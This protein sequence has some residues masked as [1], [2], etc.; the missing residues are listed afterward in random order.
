[1]AV[2]ETKGK[3]E[4]TQEAAALMSK[5]VGEIK[6]KQEGTKEAAALMANMKNKNLFMGMRSSKTSSRKYR[7]A[8]NRY[9]GKRERLCSCKKW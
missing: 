3:E 6:G 4:R 8:K 7:T 9:Y 5:I 1:M 2:G